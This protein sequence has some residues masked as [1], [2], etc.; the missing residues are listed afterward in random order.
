MLC[1]CMDIKVPCHTFM[2]QP[3]Q[4]ELRSSLSGGWFPSTS[5]LSLNVSI[6]S[7]RILWLL[8]FDDC[9]LSNSIHRLQGLHRDMSNSREWWGFVEVEI[10][11]W[12]KACIEVWDACDYLILVALVFEGDHVPFDCYVVRFV[13]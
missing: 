13:I 8:C 10:T 11:D 4:M 6:A 7:Y 2:C 9:H 1:L 5:Q 12:R 3:T